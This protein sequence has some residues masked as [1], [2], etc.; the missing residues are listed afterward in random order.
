MLDYLCRPENL[1]VF[2]Y[3][4]N[5][6]YNQISEHI[7][8][9]RSAGQ[10]KNKLAS[11][12]NRYKKAQRQFQKWL[13]VRSLE[14]D[15]MTSAQKKEAYDCFDPPVPE[16]PHL[17]TVFKAKPTRLRVSLLSLETTGQ[18][19]TIDAASVAMQSKKRRI[20]DMDG[21]GF[22]QSPTFSVRRHTEGELR[23]LPRPPTCSGP[24]D[25]TTVD[26]V[27]STNHSGLRSGNSQ[28]PLMP[29][30][31]STETTITADSGRPMS[32]AYSR[33]DSN[34]SGLSPSPSNF[35]SPLSGWAMGQ[36]S[37][38]TSYHESNRF[39]SL[40]PRLPIDQ[41]RN[42]IA[43][44]VH[45]PNSLM[46]GQQPAGSASGDTHRNSD[47]SS[48]TTR[49]EHVSTLA[50]RSLGPEEITLHSRELMIREREQ[51]HQHRLDLMRQQHEYQINMAQIALRQ[52]ELAVREKEADLAFQSFATSQA[53]L[54]MPRRASFAP[55]LEC[56]RIG[57]PMRP[58]Q[59]AFRGTRH[60]SFQADTSTPLIN[61]T[62]PQ[63][64][65]LPSPAETSDRAKADTSSSDASDRSA[66]DLLNLPSDDLL[67]YRT[68]ATPEDQQPHHSAAS[69]QDSPSHYT[70]PVQHNYV[71][72]SLAPAPG[73]SSA[74]PGEMLLIAPPTAHVYGSSD[75]LHSALSSST[76][77]TPGTVT[78]V[79]PADQLPYA[80]KPIESQYTQSLRSSHN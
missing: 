46:A 4:K 9:D 11:L 65:T 41:R 40:S 3:N 62:A 33:Q 55:S 22:L 16:F 19:P 6:C 52:R 75:T 77:H 74:A 20:D 60:M 5:Y 69:Q 58:K 31:V 53:P 12:E 32:R 36:S 47:A 30:S 29:P 37:R 68:T 80:S 13:E 18:Q 54:G 56:Y 66:T 42:S 49:I 21:T 78:T 63:A 50:N 8:R 1:R 73:G 17:D 7:L 76:V 48:A 14:A 23:G 64:A 43:A 67:K 59:T 24:A 70:M 39:L 2:L 45:A 44:I 72:S 79:A 34:I 28:L 15:A 51:E 38:K 35:L 71:L 57:S 25:S 10:I 61:V 26:A 27:G